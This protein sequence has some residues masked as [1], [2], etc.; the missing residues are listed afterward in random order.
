[1]ARCGV[2]RRDFEKGTATC[3]CGKTVE[4]PEFIS[5]QFR[6]ANSRWQVNDAYRSLRDFIH[7][8]PMNL[9]NQTYK[10]VVL[11]FYGHATAKAARFLLFDTNQNIWI[12]K[13]HLDKDMNIKP[14]EDIDYI[15]NSW[16][17]RHKI[18]LAKGVAK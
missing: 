7:K 12:P 16:Q 1:M 3:S 14:G 18:E 13:K 8:S 15:V 4:E 2:V 10:D 5:A 9:K 6:D 17:T 11:R